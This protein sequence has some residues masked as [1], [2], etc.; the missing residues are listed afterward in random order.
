MQFSASW[1][2]SCQKLPEMNKSSLKILPVWLLGKG[3][4]LLQAEPKVAENFL[5]WIDPV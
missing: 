2:Q 1:N 4:A 5:K 3:E